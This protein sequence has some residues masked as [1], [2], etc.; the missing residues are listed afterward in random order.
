MDFLEIHF[1]AVVLWFKS[2][3]LTLVVKML[4]CMLL[5]LWIRCGGVMELLQ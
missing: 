4:V 1:V 3:W 2:E 5:V